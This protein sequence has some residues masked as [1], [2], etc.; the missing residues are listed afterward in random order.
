MKTEDLALELFKGMNSRDF[1]TI[2]PYFSEELVLDFPG[3]GEIAGKRRVIVF[4]NALLRKYPDLTFNVR[5]VLVDEDLACAV[6]TNKGR[7]LAGEPY[8]NAGI[9]LF[10]LEDGMITYLSDYFKD[11]SFAL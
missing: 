7:N 1:S 11:T 6:W 9:T 4:M 2:E 8:Q 3:S 5:E 10:H